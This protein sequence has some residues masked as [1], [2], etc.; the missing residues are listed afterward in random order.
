MSKQVFYD[1]ITVYLCTEN[2]QIPILDLMLPIESRVDRR[3]SVLNLLPWFGELRRY[4]EKGPLLPRFS[5]F[6]ESLSWNTF[7]DFRL[8]QFSEIDEVTLTEEESNTY[9]IAIGESWKVFHVK[10]SRDLTHEEFVVQVCL[11]LMI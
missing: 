7:R 10:L 3:Q 5:Y 9:Q 2:R 11:A 1:Q 4:F 8:R 6:L